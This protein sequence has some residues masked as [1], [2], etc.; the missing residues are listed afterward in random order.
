MYAVLPSAIGRKHI[1]ELTVPLRGRLATR[2][3][4]EGTME[5]LDLFR[6]ARR[7]L[8]FDSPSSEANDSSISF[9]LATERGSR[10]IL[11]MRGTGPEPFYSTC[12][13]RASSEGR[14]TCRSRT[15]RQAAL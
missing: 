13:C 3:D 4:W 1:H 7:I 8:F 5:V 2:Y 15:S 6:R 14:N 10:T 12:E 9:E 11:R